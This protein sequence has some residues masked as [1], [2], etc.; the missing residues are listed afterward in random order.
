MSKPHHKSSRWIILAWSL[1]GLG[2]IVLLFVLALYWTR[3]PS[4]AAAAPFVDSQGTPYPT[5][6]PAPTIYY[7]PTITPNAPLGIIA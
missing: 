1:N 3:P 7:L 4:R 5:L 6:T 2:L